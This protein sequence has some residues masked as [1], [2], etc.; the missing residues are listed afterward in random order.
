MG[1]PISKLRNHP[2]SADVLNPIRFTVHILP[3]LWLYNAGAE[4]L[5]A[6]NT[7]IVLVYLL[8]IAI[9][10]TCEPSPPYNSSQTKWYSISYP[11]G[12]E[13]W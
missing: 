3:V 7:I 8:V 2:S 11:G 4:T 9:L 6:S 1:P 13:G 12:I 5:V 10:D